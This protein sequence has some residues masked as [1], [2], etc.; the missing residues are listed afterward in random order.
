MEDVHVV[1]AEEHEQII[2]ELTQTPE[3]CNMQLINKDLK[4]VDPFSPNLTLEQKEAILEECKANP[5]YFYDKVLGIK[6][7]R[8][9]WDMI[10]TLQTYPKEA[11][12]D[13]DGDMLRDGE[14]VSWKK[15]EEMTRNTPATYPPGDDQWKVGFLCEPGVAAAQP[16]HRTQSIE[17]Q[18]KVMSINQLANQAHKAWHLTMQNCEVRDKV[19]AQEVVEIFNH[20]LKNYDLG[21]YEV[22]LSS[23]TG[24]EESIWLSKPTFGYRRDD[25]SEWMPLDYVAAVTIP[26]T[27]FS[28]EEVRQMQ[29]YATNL[30]KLTYQG[31]GVG[32]TNDQRE[33]AFGRFVFEVY[34]TD[35]IRASI[36]GDA[37]NFRY[38]DRDGHWKVL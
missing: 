32:C 24:A 1:N 12:G 31:L 3:D 9:T 20:I 22:R 38:L 13:H 36:D 15:L 30:W 37:V 11:P 26:R 29:A 28:A 34:G 2:K 10:R 17:V 19:T 33:D 27:L 25:K 8:M 6:A 16:K 7:S 4:M 18:H 23:L 14:P 35:R 5:M 21:G